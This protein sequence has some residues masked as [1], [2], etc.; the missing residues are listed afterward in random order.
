MNQQIKIRMTGRKFADLKPDKASIGKMLTKWVADGTVPKGIKLTATEW[1]RGELTGARRRSLTGQAT[2]V[3][4]IV[5]RYHRAGVTLCD[6]D[7]ADPPTLSI[8]WALAGR[9]KLRPLWVEYD[10]TERGWHVIVEWHRTLTPGETVAL[11]LLMGSDPDRECY[12]LARLIAGAGKTKR[13]N[14]LFERKL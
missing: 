12:N 1:G 7:H 8:L 10:R 6:Y 11:Q 13:F 2:R 5:K 9:L 14:L 4:G 3:A